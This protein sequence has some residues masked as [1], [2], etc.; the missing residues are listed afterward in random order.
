MSVVSFVT[1]KRRRRKVKNCGWL[2]WCRRDGTACVFYL[3][4]PIHYF[5]LSIFVTY[6]KLVALF[7]FL[8]L[9]WFFASDICHALP[10]MYVSRMHEERESACIESVFLRKKEAVLCRDLTFLF[11]SSRHMFCLF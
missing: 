9:L 1:L 8:L 4:P 6:A 7:F 11:P 5:F 3:N 10:S 2:C